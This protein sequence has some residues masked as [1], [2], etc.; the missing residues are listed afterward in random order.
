[1]AKKQLFTA[2]LKKSEKLETLGYLRAPQPPRY[3]TKG[4]RGVIGEMKKVR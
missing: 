2:T 3:T 1:L 4:A